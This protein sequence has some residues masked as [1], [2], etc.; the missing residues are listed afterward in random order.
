MVVAFALVF[1]GIARY[2]L[3]RLAGSAAMQVLCVLLWLAAI[4]VRADSGHAAENGPW[5]AAV[6]WQ[7]VHLLAISVWSGCVLVVAWLLRSIAEPQRTRAFLASL[8]RAATVALG[9]VL[10][11]GAVKAYLSLAPAA[12][13][14][15]LEPWTCILTAKLAAVGIALA[16]A[17][18]NRSLLRVRIWGEGERHSCRINLGIESVAML[19]ILLLS[20][21]LGGTAPPGE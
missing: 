15:P 2:S 1:V 11:S 16:C 21:M 19:V 7:L 12:H 14:L 4:A 20:A 17:L 9:G 6:A 18:K 3:R 13:L 8:S 10:L 5:T